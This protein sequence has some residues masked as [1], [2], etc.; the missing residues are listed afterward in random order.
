MDLRMPRLDGP[1]ALRRIRQE[2]GL[3]D[4]TPILA[5]TADADDV[6]AGQLRDM[7]FDG[8]VPK[9]IDSTTL[10]ATV[11]AATSIDSA[12]EDLRHVG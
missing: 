4:H 11:A 9:P 1:G 6:L 5:F 12:R 7:G 8:V 3:N 10:L 2:G